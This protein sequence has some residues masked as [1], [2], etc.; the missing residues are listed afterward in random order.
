ME[1]HRN[2]Q[3]ME[4]FEKTETSQYLLNEAV[5]SIFRIVYQEKK[6][7]NPD[8][9]LMNNLEAQSVFFKSLLREPKNFRSLKSMDLI[10]NQF[11]P[12]L[13]DLRKIEHD[14]QLS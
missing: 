6:S 10:I 13:N 9:E 3:P 1:V 11:T 5:T 14:Q 8:K 4:W 12:I 7:P 2:S